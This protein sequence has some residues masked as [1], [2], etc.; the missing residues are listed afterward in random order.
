MY[1]APVRHGIG[2]IT[3]CFDLLFFFV[4]TFPVRAAFVGM[5]IG[6]CEPPDVAAQASSSMVQAYMFT[7]LPVEVRGA[8]GMYALCAHRLDRGWREVHAQIGYMVQSLQEAEE[9][10]RFQ[11]FP[12][13]A[14]PRMQVRYRHQSDI[15]LFI[16]PEYDEY[17]RSEIRAQYGMREVGEEDRTILACRGWQ[18]WGDLL[19]GLKWWY[20]MS[21]EQI[22]PWQRVYNQSY[23]AVGYR[24]PRGLPDDV[25]PP[26]LILRECVHCASI[27][28]IKSVGGGRRGKR[29]S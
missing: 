20:C 19:P 9:T 4:V 2:L 23:G 7:N 22:G 16:E 14:N 29:I 13:S 6:A 26:G 18:Y 15:H 24:N 17:I 11:F 28:G 10:D 21:C 3:V 27:E 12:L 8:I 1:N 5:M 25:H